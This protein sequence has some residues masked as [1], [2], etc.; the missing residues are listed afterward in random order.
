VIGSLL[1]PHLVRKDVPQD[2]PTRTPDAPGWVLEYSRVNFRFNEA[3]YRSCTG[4]LK[5][6]PHPIVRTNEAMF[7]DMPGQVVPRYFWRDAGH[8]KR[9]GIGYSMVIDGRPASTAFAAFVHGKQLEIGIETAGQYRGKG[10]AV[11]V[12]RALIGHCLEK[13]H[14]PIWSCRLENVGSFHLAGKLGFEPILYVPYYQ[15]ISHE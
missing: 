8:F 7:M 14:E 13:G 12:C 4:Q 2:Q 11:H 1:G 9:Q 15:L 6:P 3:L 10:Y 5:K